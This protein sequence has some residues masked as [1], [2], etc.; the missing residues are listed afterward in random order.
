[1]K[2]RVEPPYSLLILIFLYVISGF[3]SIL[4]FITDREL[5]VMGIAML[6]VGI[7]LFLRSIW[8]FLA[9]RA[10]VLF[11]SVIQLPFFLLTLMGGGTKTGHMF[12]FG[13]SVEISFWVAYSATLLYLL[14][15]VYVAFVTSRIFQNKLMN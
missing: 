12:F 8:S 10:L 15:Q 6:I 7:A 5:D 13:K 3:S 4:Q 1:M 11:Y 2:E 9:L 14:F